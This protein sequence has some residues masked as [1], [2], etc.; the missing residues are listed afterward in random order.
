MDLSGVEPG[1]M[2]VTF[3]VKGL[4]GKE[5][6]VTFTETF[7]GL[8]QPPSMEPRQGMEHMEGHEGMK[9]PEGKGDAGHD[10]H[11]MH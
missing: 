11:G 10:M 9:H 5:K 8:A 3:H 1:S 7:T 6:E 4:P 2:K